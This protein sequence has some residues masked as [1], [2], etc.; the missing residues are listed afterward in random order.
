MSGEQIFL[1][2][3]G[4]IV[5]AIIVIGVPL[6]CASENKNCDEIKTSGYTLAMINANLFLYAQSYLIPKLFFGVESMWLSVP[7]VPVAL[8]YTVVTFIINAILIRFFRSLTF[9]ENTVQNEEK[10]FN[11]AAFALIL[12][13][14][15]CPFFLFVIFVDWLIK[16]PS[17]KKSK[18]L[19]E[20]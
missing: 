1:Y 13:P 4:S 10:L 9:E 5:L 2:I 3:I 18:N 14:L 7:V 11:E 20:L 17:P 15:S 16:Q 12:S 8:I 6:G 19:N